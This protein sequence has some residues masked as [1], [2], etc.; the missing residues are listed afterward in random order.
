MKLQRD[1]CGAQYQVPRCF[2]WDP[3]KRFGLGGQHKLTATRFAGYSFAGFAN[4]NGTESFSP[5]LRWT[6]WVGI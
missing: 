4:P 6:S 2:P 5:R 3:K 1:L